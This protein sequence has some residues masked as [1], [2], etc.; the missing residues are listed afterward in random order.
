MG[1]RIFERAVTI[2]D[3]DIFMSPLS[4]SIYI[5]INDIYLIL[6]GNDLQIIN[7][8]YQ[9]DLHYNEQVRSRMRDKVLQVIESKKAAVEQRIRAKS[10]RTL[11]SILEDITILRDSEAKEIEL[12]DYFLDLGICIAIATESEFNQFGGDFVRKIDNAVL[13][14]YV[15]IA[16]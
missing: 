5:E 9:Y 12:V 13:C 1:I 16:D 15:P 2:K 11:H 7:G 3:V 8:K 4:D 10:D 14:T 6:D